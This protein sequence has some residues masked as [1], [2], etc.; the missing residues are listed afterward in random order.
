MSNQYTLAD[1][2]KMSWQEFETAAVGAIRRLY[3][4]YEIE[5]SNTPLSHDE[6]RDGEAQH[7]LAI[8]LGPELAISIKVFLEIK[9]RKDENVGKSDI[10]SHVVDAFRNKVTKVIFITNREFTDPLSKWLSEFCGPLNIQFS[11]VPGKRLLEWLNRPD[12]TSDEG[13]AITDWESFKKS[14]SNKEARAINGHLTYTLDPNEAVGG[15]APCNARSDRPVFAIIDLTVGDEV[16]PFH[17]VVELT[18]KEA[19]TAIIH[20]TGRKS[21]VIFSPGERH[22]WVFAIWPERP[23]RWD[24]S[25]FE[26]TLRDENIPLLIQSTN[27]F[28][29]P[30]QGLGVAIA[31]PQ[32]S[33]ERTILS[34]FDSWCTHGGLALRFLLSPGGLGKS[35]LVGR[36]RKEW[37]AQ[38]LREVVL[39]GETV[40]DDIKLI[41]R[42]FSSLFP[43]PKSPFDDGAKPA[44]VSW[45]SGL[46]LSP[47][48]CEAVASDLCRPSGFQPSHY[49]ANLRAEMFAALL[50]EGGGERGLVFVLEDLHKV[51]PSVLTVIEEGLSLLRASGRGKIFVLLTSRP[52]QEIGS[53]DITSDWLAR[54]RRLLALAEDAVSEILPPSEHDAREILHRTAPS[55]EATH[56]HE[57]VEQVGTAPFNLRETVLYLRQ[58]KVLLVLETGG[59][60]VLADPSRLNE[61]LKHEGLKG[62]TRRRLDVFF[63]DQPPWLRKLVEAGA[64]YG[65]QF[66]FS[67]M[68]RAVGVE[69]RDQAIQAVADAARWSLM[70]VSPEQRENLEFDHDLVRSAVLALMPELRRREVADALL[71]VIDDSEETVR[72]AG[73]AYQAGHADRAFELARQAAHEQNARGRPADALKANHIALLTLD[74][75]WTRFDGQSSSWGDVAILSAPPTR[76]QFSD[77]QQRDRAALTVLRDD[78]RCLGTV[79]AGSSSLSDRILTEAR[80]L[81]ERLGDHA[82][83]ASLIAME[84][85]LLF[86]RNDIVGALQAHE[87]A[88]GM[89]AVLSKEESLDRADN[90]VRLAIC[91]RQLGQIDDSL[92]TLRQALKHRVRLDWTLVNKVRSNTGAAYLLTDWNKVRHHWERQLRSARTHGLI[93]RQAHAL[94]GLSFINLFDG[95]QSEGRRQAEQALEIAKAQ[96]LDN[97]RVRCDLNLAVSS[98]MDRNMDGAL[99]YLYEA[100]S[101]AIKHQIDRRLWR[102]YANF[103]TAYELIGQA[104]KAKARDLQTVTS[105]K[106][107]TWESDGLLQRGRNLLP[108]INIAFRA[109]LAPEVYEPILQ[110]F[111]PETLLILQEIAR[112]LAVG[113][114]SFLADVLVKYLVNVNGCRRFLLTE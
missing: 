8:G 94:A 65:R 44:L 53:V 100:E 3:S 61:L 18:S 2:H 36:L 23:G 91:Q 56:V 104:E 81:S 89:F 38:G 55:L 20:D 66:P 79:S 21:A 92:R 114:K 13:S 95:R 103:A 72:I 75:A 82:G 27:V 58:L 25:C 30:E 39:D 12:S 11:L 84:G 22:R 63:R 68:V 42:T 6:G 28:Y 37:E 71:N 16:S 51:S 102:V 74:P 17:G 109:T 97:T 34:G 107:D 93:P 64:C 41:E 110:R 78:L 14:T 7:I 99:N 4:K 9:K 29:F 10:G 106:A 40:G 113:E 69:D 45:L 54:L 87:K 26:I 90:L 5:I 77:W 73:L 59:R 67:L 49:S 52:A 15:T 85:R 62:T 105:L 32:N 101:L 19:G 111:R 43:F 47:E 96:G 88:E 1:L 50:S 57:I 98:L 108:L 33:V 70:T 31:S 76:R 86:E 60:P 24:D 83:S 80:M 112:K 35:F 48:A 46:K